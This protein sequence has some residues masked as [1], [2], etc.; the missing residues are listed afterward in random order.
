MTPEGLAAV[1]LRSETCCVVKQCAGAGCKLRLPSSGKH[2]C[3]CGTCYQRNH[4]HTEPLCD[5]ILFWTS[6]HDVVAI[7]ELKTTVKAEECLR[8]LRNGAAVAELRTPKNITPHD[9]V[10]LIVHGSM[11]SAVVVKLAGK[12]VKYRG[13]EYLIRRIKCGADL[14]TAMRRR[15]FPNKRRSR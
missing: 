13:K 14:E 2:A 3:I 9:I 11:N 7:V 1:V 12:T 4:G 5:C 15:V 8:Q 10:P 6:Q